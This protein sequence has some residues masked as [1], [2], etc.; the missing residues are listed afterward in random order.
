MRTRAWVK[1]LVV[2]GLIGGAGLALA[3]PLRIVEMLH[4]VAESMFPA[5]QTPPNYG[6]TS[7]SDCDSG[8]CASCASQWNPTCN[9]LICC[10]PPQGACA[11][12]ADCCFADGLECD[13]TLKKCCN[14]ALGGVHQ[15]C[16][17]NVDCCQAPSGLY[18]QY[19]CN[20]DGGVCNI[21]TNNLYPPD[22]I[23]HEP[24][25]SGQPA[26]SDGNCCSAVGQSCYPGVLDGGELPDAGAQVPDAGAGILNPPT[27]GCCQGAPY[28]ATDI[29]IC[30]ANSTCCLIDNS[31]CMSN[32]ECCSGSCKLGTMGYK[33]CSGAC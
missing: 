3:S 22:P 5:G 27:S 4:R 17:D 20:T 24:C 28:G 14:S 23:H 13:S 19:Y 26:G 25:C 8:V 21:C 12:D 10:V 33:V 31:K 7:A 6:C 11:Q 30:S 2:G 18:Y 15:N 9:A 16:L 29:A 1:M 32:S